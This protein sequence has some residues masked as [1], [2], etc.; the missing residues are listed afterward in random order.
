MHV[1]LLKTLCFQSKD[2]DFRDHPGKNLAKAL[3]EHSQKNLIPSVQCQ[4]GTFAT[5]LTDKLQV[6]HDCYKT[7]YAAE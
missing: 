6:F 7:L 2:S 1:Q 3:D 4:D 5:D